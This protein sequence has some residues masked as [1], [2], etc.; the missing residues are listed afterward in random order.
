MN[1]QR[2]IPVRILWGDGSLGGFCFIDK[3]IIKYWEVMLSKTVKT[4]K[5]S[6]TWFIIVHILLDL[7]QYA[8]KYNITLF[9]TVC[10]I[11]HYNPIYH[12]VS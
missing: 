10:N 5:Y 4:A 11:L 9:I 1:E 12:S 8:L 2:W 3:T 6:I 7:L